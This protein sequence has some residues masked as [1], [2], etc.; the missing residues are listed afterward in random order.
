MN[1]GNKGDR[2]PIVE[3]RDGSSDMN[4][5]PNPNTPSRAWR[6]CTFERCDSYMHLP[7]SAELKLAQMRPQDEAL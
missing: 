1:A 6:T 5:G 3:L 2:L 4:G 7:L